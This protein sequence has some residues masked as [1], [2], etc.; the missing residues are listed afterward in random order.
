MAVITALV[1]GCSVRSTSRMTGV[2][3]GT[4][5]RLLEDVG[6]ACAE[7]QDAGIAEYL[8]QARSGR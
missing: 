7:Y 2:V 8:G 5:L 1:E 4:I 3:K 6:T